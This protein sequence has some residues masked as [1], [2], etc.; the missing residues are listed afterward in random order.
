MFTKIDALLIFADSIAPP[1]S[2]LHLAL[3]WIRYFIDKKGLL[4]PGTIDNYL[5]RVFLNGLLCDPESIDLSMWEP[6]DH[7]L[8]FEDVLSR[9]SIKHAST[10]MGIYN[11]YK[12]VYA[13]AVTNKFCCPVNLS[14]VSDEWIGGSKR[15][16]L[17]GLGEFDTFINLLLDECSRSSVQLAVVCILA[18]YGGMRAGEISSLTL[19]DLVICDEHH[20]VDLHKGKT[21]AARREI[22]LHLLAPES[23]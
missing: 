20:Y 11:T 3:H 9:E 1:T 17:I 4:S 8:A 5:S 18:F 7:V 6:E 22:P 23:T 16:E 13:Y 15:N 19:K 10:R 12:Q 2:A 21:A 14:Y